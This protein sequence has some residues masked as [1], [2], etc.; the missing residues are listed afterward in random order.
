MH[1]YWI[2]IYNDE[3]K[4]RRD[5]MEHTLTDVSNTMIKAYTPYT[6]P[7]LIK[8]RS[9][10]ST[11][12]K[13]EEYACTASH[14]K[15]MQQALY[16]N[17]EYAIIVE[18]D[19]II[20][21]NVDFEKLIDTAPND[22]EILQ[23]CTNNTKMLLNNFKTYKND[24]EL[25]A[26][27]TFMSWCTTGYIIKADVMRKLVQI[28]MYEENLLDVSMITLTKAVADIVIY[29]NKKTYT[30]TYPC[31]EALNISSNI[32]PEHLSMH[33]ESSTLTKNIL[34][35]YDF[36]KEISRIP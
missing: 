35:H 7:K 14:L 17:Q 34:D 31:F 19:I 29:Q 33:V 30:L 12:T 13:L 28:H 6:L 32:H 1:V 5:H 22:W 20:P 11:M 24:K 8:E 27:W 26:P 3:N 36:P 9:I 2:N 18:D 15:A 23:L 16:D 25:W 4:Y 21:R 10:A